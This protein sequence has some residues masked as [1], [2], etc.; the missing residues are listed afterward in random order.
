VRNW[1]D[2][3]IS[4]EKKEREK[5]IILGQAGVMINGIREMYVE[6]C[7]LVTS[8]TAMTYLQT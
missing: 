8:S 7:M 2:G 3:A 6:K 1:K 4:N 5:L